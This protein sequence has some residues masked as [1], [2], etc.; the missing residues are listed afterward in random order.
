MPGESVKVVKVA[1]P[2]LTA[3]EPIVFAPSMKVT[4]PV[5]PAELTVAVIVTLWPNVEG[6][7]DDISVIVVEAL[8]TTC[9][10]TVDV[11]PVNTESPL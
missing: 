4:L 6:F 10:S 5:T 11:L 8:F 9:V 1:T 3:L 2:L 7:C